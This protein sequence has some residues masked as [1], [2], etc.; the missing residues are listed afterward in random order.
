MLDGPVGAAGLRMSAA[1]EAADLIGRRPMIG[2]V[3]LELA[4]DRYRFWAIVHL[5]RDLP[6]ILKD[7]DV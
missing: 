2:R 6:N 4:S 1:L 3:R 5:S 7:L